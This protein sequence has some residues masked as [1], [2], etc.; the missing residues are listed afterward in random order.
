MTTLE[1]GA[2]VV[3]THGLRDSPRST[4]FFARSAAPIITYGLDVFVQEV[5]AA[6]TT[7]PW[8]SVVSVPSSRVTLTGCV[9]R[10][11]SGVGES[12]AGKD[13]LSEPKYPGSASR[14]AGFAALN[15]VRSC[16]RLGPA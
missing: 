12:E 5:I 2:R 15:S 9:A 1:P 14:N 3:L 6:I 8:S 13:P 16:G 4:A 10:V 11:A 7:W